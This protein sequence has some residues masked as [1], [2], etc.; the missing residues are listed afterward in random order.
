MRVYI[1]SRTT[2]H[3]N[4]KPRHSHTNR[5]WIDRQKAP[6]HSQTPLAFHFSISHPFSE[7]P[8]H[9]FLSTVKPRALFILVW[10]S[11]Q[12]IPALTKTAT[13][14]ER[15]RKLWREWQQCNMDTAWPV[16]AA[17]RLPHSRQIFLYLHGF[18]CARPGIEC[19]YFTDI[20]VRLPW[21][22][23]AQRMPFFLAHS[24]VHGMWLSAFWWLTVNWDVIL[25]MWMLICRK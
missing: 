16:I 1:L 17:K 9:F 21:R 4:K 2:D 18:A 24:F 10:G 7:W 20:W 14:W 12:S 19:A 8:E 6:T 11:T 23:C 15:V 3:A 25:C 13:L 22:W 5:R